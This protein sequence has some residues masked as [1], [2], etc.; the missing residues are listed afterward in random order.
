MYQNRIANL[1]IDLFPSMVIVKGLAS[2]SSDQAVPCQQQG[3]FPL[4]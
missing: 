4:L 1:K 2:L 3:F